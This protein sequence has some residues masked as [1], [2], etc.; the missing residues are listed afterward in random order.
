MAKSAAHAWL[1]SVS[2]GMVPGTKM[3]SSVDRNG[4]QRP[5]TC[6]H[7]NWKHSSKIQ[8]VWCTF[9]LLCALTNTRHLFFVCN[10]AHTKVTRCSSVHLTF[11]TFLIFAPAACAVPV[12]QH[13]NVLSSKQPFTSYVTRSIPNSRDQPPGRISCHAHNCL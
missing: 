13:D 12:I 7:S 5:C 3:V 6:V 8:G 1:P 11:A 10:Y 4:C 9:M 2:T